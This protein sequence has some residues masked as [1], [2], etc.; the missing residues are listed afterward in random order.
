VSERVLAVGDINADLLLMGLDRLPV[1]EQE[2][3]AS[4]MAVLIGGQTG[5]VARTLARLGR[6]VC[7]VGRVGDDEYGRAALHSLR[8]EGVDCRGVVVDPAVRTGLTVVLSTG[9]QRAYATYA[10]CAAQTRRGDVTAEQLDSARHLHVGSYY[11]QKALRPALPGL[12]REARSRGLTTS[13]D[14]GWDPAGEWGPEIRELLGEVDVFLPNEAEAAAI[15]ATRDPE[16]A[17]RALVG[18]GRI[19]VLKMG[20]AGC[21]ASDGNLTLRCPA[22]QVPVADVTSA[23]DVFDAGFLHAHLSGW[24]LARSLRFASA[25]GAIAVSRPGTGGIVTGTAQVLEF[26]GGKI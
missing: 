8:A 22:F 16:T 26:L 21:V 15:A 18:R 17:L 20:D 5:T 3:L 12:F 2:V 23:G 9:A 10:G 19:V 1:A 6:P 7:F 24:D 25:C 13:L 14:P 4:D 11:L